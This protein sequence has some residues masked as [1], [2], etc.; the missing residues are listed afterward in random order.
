MNTDTRRHADKPAYNRKSKY[1]DD[2]LD[3]VESDEDLGEPD[4]E[5]IALEDEQTQ[6]DEDQE[7]QGGGRRKQGGRA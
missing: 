6:D 7:N 3:G 2:P 1:R 5:A 4:D